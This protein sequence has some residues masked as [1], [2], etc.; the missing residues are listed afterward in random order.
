MQQ[1]NQVHFPKLS[2]INKKLLI[3]TFALFLLDSL[4]MK[5]ANGGSFLSILHLNPASVLS[6][7]VYQFLT[8]PFLSLGL[9]SYLFAALLIWFVGCELETLWGKKKYIF[10][11]CVSCIGAGLI[12]FILSLIM[13]QSGM[14]YAPLGGL[15]GM[16][17]ALI[18]AYGILFPERHFSFMFVF[19]IKA[20]Y[21]CAII[22]GVLTYQAFFQQGFAAIGHLLH[23][24]MGFAAML[25]M[26]KGTVKNWLEG[27][28][29]KSSKPSLRSKRGGGHLKLVKTD[30][31]DDK[32]PKY[33]Q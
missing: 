24:G 22:I 32:P 31:D 16:S 8:F 4:L 14:A 12:Y 23:M 6:G 15:Q 33:L 20:K 28:G 11:L 9:W 27:L 2:D 29:E 26:T 25:L 18:L 5:F 1:Y 3:L 30:D 21:F 17:E 13:A 19:P 7:H 10:F